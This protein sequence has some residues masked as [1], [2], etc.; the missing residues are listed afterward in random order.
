MPAPQACIA[1]CTEFGFNT[2]FLFGQIRVA[3][4][5]KMPQNMPF[6]AL[7]LL[8]VYARDGWQ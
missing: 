4:N 5:K 8:V 1:G 6:L 7:D 3:V 2:A